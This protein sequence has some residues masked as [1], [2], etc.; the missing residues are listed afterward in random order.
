MKYVLFFIHFVSCI[1]I[2]IKMLKIEKTNSK[3]IN[4]N[5]WAQV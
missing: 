4:Q 1:L 2:K 5:H 3:Y